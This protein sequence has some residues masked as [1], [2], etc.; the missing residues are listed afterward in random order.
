MVRPSRCRRGRGRRVRA[1]RFSAPVTADRVCS[2]IRRSISATTVATTARAVAPGGLRHHPVETD[3][4]A[5]QVDV[6]LHRR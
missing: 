6:G 3:Q 5:D 2:A 1:A 4:R